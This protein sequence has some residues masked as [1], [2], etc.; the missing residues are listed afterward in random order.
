M[1]DV[2]GLNYCINSLFN[3]KCM[4]GAVM[5]KQHNLILAVGDMTAVVRVQ[6]IQIRTE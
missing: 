1:G 4:S 2:F 6:N 3:K 5:I